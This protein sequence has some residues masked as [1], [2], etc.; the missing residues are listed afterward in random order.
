MSGGNAQ[1]GTESGRVKGLT[2]NGEAM[3]DTGIQTTEEL[4]QEQEESLKRLQELLSANGCINADGILN[5]EK[6]VLLISPFG[7][8][9]GVAFRNEMTRFEMIERPIIDVQN[10]MTKDPEFQKIFE[11]YI[12]EPKDVIYNIERPTGWLAEKI[13]NAVK[14]YDG[15]G[16]TNEELFL[17]V[18]NPGAA[19]TV[20][21]NQSVTDKYVS[22]YFEEHVDGNSANAFRHAMFAALNSIMLGTETASDFVNAHENIEGNDSNSVREDGKKYS[23]H[24]EMDLHNNA[25][26]LAIG[27]IMLMNSE[28]GFVSY[29]E[30]AEIVYDIVITQ[31]YGVWIIDDQ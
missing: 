19:L 9:A 14:K 2:Q 16:L 30:L 23:E 10:N 17:A 24:M 18:N 8:E 1:D 31:G 13:D 3:Q 11:E 25:V 12:T 6:I 26:G 29:D 27:S 4:A 22:K 15:R 28:D 5:E 20:N 7:G 21:E